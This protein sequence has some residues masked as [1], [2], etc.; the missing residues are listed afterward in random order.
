MSNNPRKYDPFETYLGAVIYHC[1]ASG[2]FM[3]DGNETYNLNAARERA[4]MSPS[5]Y[6]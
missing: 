3:V 4:A 5:R 1:S 6:L 2:L